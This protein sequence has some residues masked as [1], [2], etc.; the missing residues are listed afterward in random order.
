MTGSGH[1]EPERTENF[2]GMRFRKVHS[3]HSMRR[4]NYWKKFYEPTHY[5]RV[6]KER[7]GWIHIYVRRKGR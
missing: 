7:V 6:E 3:V 5:V 1:K 2:G 4:A